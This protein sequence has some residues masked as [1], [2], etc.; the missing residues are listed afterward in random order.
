MNLYACEFSF[1]AS[2]VRITAMVVERTEDRAYDVFLSRLQEDGYAPLSGD[3]LCIYHP[4]HNRALKQ[5]LT[6]YKVE[7]R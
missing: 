3:I 6:D 7:K 4:Y 1:P 2:K 5:G